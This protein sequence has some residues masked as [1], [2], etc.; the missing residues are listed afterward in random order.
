LSIFFYGDGENF[1]TR[2]YNGK[3]SEPSRADASCLR[4]RAW[5]RCWL[6][7]SFLAGRNEVSSGG[8]SR[9]PDYRHS[10]AQERCPVWSVMLWMGNF[11]W[12]LPS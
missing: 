4:P 1:L 3:A 11:R 8:P 10:I 9:Q 12:D 5:V 7:R 6:G 2:I